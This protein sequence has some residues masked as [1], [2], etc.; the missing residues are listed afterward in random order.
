MHPKFTRMR[1]ETI[2]SS[3]KS[4]KNERYGQK[5]YG[6]KMKDLSITFSSR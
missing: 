3:G 5:F 1:N 2:E 4:K 6:T